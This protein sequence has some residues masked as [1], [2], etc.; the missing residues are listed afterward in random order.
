MDVAIEEIPIW[1]K[2]EYRRLW[3]RAVNLPVVDATEQQHNLF[4][5]TSKNGINY[6][7]DLTHAHYG[8]YGETITPWQFYVN[9]RV[10]EIESKNQFGHTFSWTSAKA[11]TI[12]GIRGKSHVLNQSF[13]VIVKECARRT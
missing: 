12:S 5:V 8:H 13:G 3:I 2:P 4:P 11:T 6:A 1:I 10:R 7:I 9:T